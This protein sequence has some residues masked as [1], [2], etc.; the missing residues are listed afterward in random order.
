M[1]GRAMSLSVFLASFSNSARAVLSRSGEMVDGEAGF[2]AA[3]AA[4]AD[5]LESVADTIAVK[6][7]SR[8]QSEGFMADRVK[9]R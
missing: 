4:V 5:G 7:T 9:L 3:S 8:V 2:G 6:Q 1:P